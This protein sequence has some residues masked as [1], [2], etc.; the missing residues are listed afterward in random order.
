MVIEDKTRII[1]TGDIAFSRY[2]QDGW[3][4]GDCI[5]DEVKEYLKNADNVVINLESPLTNREIT[6]TK[7]LTH[8]SNPKAGKYISEANMNIWN[9]ANNHIMDCGIGGVEDTLK[10]AQ[11]NCCRTLGAGFNI[12]EALEPVVL[13]ETVKIGI[14][15]V[16]SATWRYQMANENTPGVVTWDKTDYLRNSITALRQAVDWIVLVVHGGDENC[17]ISMPYMRDI[18]HGLLDLGADIIVGHHPHVVQDYERVGKKIIFYSLGNFIFDTENQRRFFHTE[19]GILLQID[20]GR[21]NF[22]FDCMGVHID[23]S[24]NIVCAGNIPPVFRDFDETEYSKLWPLAAR[25]FYRVNLWQR[26]E[27]SVRLRSANGIIVFGHELLA[28][29][30][31]KERIIQLGRILSVLESWRSSSSA[32][33]QEYLDEWN[34]WRHEEK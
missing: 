34:G 4:T 5:D 27:K 13:G 30:H 28:C 31:K 3:K 8:A 16:A 29:R 7:E 20:F 9:L 23:R 25:N 21:E 32:E 10:T 15:S 24:R 33:L 17:D 18:Y 19:Q 26:K 2:F 22:S 11:N 12:H 1:F 14:I 6:S